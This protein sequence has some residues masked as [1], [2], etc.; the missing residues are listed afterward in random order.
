MSG[1]TEYI[2]QTFQQL[3]HS[4]ARFTNRATREPFSQDVV[5]WNKPPKAD[6][7]AHIN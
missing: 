5:E 6:S 4:D 3:Q 7:A 1:I 2:Q